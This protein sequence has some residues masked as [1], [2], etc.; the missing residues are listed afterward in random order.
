MGAQTETRCCIT[1]SGTGGSECLPG[2]LQDAD[3]VG[4]QHLGLMIGGAGPRVA[5]NCTS[6]SAG[7]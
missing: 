6:T 2:G 1:V 4:D 5:G 3:A 7:C